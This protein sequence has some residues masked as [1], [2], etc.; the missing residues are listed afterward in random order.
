MSH[1][2]FAQEPV[3]GLPEL[4]PEGEVILWQGRPDWWAL[5]REALNIY[6][7]IGYFLFLFAWR[8]I[9]LSDQVTLAQAISGSTPFL[10]LG[11]IVCA[12]LILTAVT[13]AW[14]TVYTI[15]NRRVAMRIGAALTVTLNLPY[16]QIANATLDLRKR[17]TGTIALDLMGDTR[18]SYLVCWPHVRPW[19]IRRTQPALRCIPDAANVAKLLSEAAEKRVSNP[20]ITR[21]AA[22][23]QGSAVAAE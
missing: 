7:V 21:S 5:T 2:D 10:V 18:L 12:L 22:P 6:W 9:V 3:K 23:A 17:G 1:D 8:F 11:A 14:A 20:V 4:P 13:Q 16:T 15:T 19:V